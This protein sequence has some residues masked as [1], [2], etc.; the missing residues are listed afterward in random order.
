MKSGGRGA[1]SGCG[2]AAFGV[3]LSFAGVVLGKY[4]FCLGGDAG[5]VEDVFAASCAGVS[6]GFELL[7]P[8]VEAKSPPKREPVERAAGF[9]KSS[10]ALPSPLKPVLSLKP[11]PSPKRPL[12]G[13][14]G[15]CGVGVASSLLRLSA[16]AVSE[17]FDS[18]DNVLNE[19]LDWP[20]IDPPCAGVLAHEGSD[21]PVPEPRVTV[22]PLGSVFKP[23]NAGFDCC[24][25]APNP[26][27]P[28]KPDWPLLLLPKLVKPLFPP[29]C[30]NFAKPEPPDWAEKGLGG[31]SVVG[32]GC[33][34]APHRDCLLPIPIPPVAPNAGAFEPPI[35]EGAPNAGALG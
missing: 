3:A 34:G 12:A 5:V 19:F 23:G 17:D 11:S 2:V 31:A 16:S 20:K 35:A 32:A 28:P 26:D 24:P 29:A 33:E 22:E 7:P 4:D 15:A 21:D 27:W 30:P 8:K 10:F 1:S 18:N 14:G 9:G 6:G 25:S 13:C